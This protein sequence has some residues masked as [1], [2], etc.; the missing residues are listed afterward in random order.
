MRL[1]LAESF[2]ETYKAL[3]PKSVLRLTFDDLDAGALETKTRNHRNGADAARRGKVDKRRKEDASLRPEALRLK[4]RGLSDRAIAEHL[5][6][7]RGIRVTRQRVAKIL[8]RSDF[9]A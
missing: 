5:T 6:R 2:S 9:R 3:V 8:A 7:A 4:G 1:S